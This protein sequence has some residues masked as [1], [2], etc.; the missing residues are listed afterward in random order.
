MDLEEPVFDISDVFDKESLD[1]L[2]EIIR[3]VQEKSVKTLTLLINFGPRQI[4]PDALYSLRILHDYLKTIDPAV[5]F[6][7]HDQLPDVRN[8]VEEDNYSDGTV[9]LIENIN[10]LPS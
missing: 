8:K 3:Y 10:F 1:S 4:V 9:F 2:V 7:S 5:E 6:V